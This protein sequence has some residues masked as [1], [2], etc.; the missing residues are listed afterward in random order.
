M[1]K[2]GEGREESESKA[3]QAILQ[4]EQS[5]MDELGSVLGLIAMSA[6]IHFLSTITMYIYTHTR[7][8]EK[9]VYTNSWLR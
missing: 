9:K 4:R 7:P 6:N 5:L 2:S 8:T 1:F 3:F